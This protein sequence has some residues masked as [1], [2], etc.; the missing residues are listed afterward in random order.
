VKEFK[1][2]K[3]KRITEISEKFY[4]QIIEM[5]FEE[6]QAILSMLK[7]MTEI[8]FVPNVIKLETPVFDEN[9]LDKILERLAEKIFK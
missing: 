3:V 5:N 8:G 4:L 6:Q 9:K 7:T 2:E 1:I